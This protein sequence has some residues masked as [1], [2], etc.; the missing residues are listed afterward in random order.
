MLCFLNLFWFKIEILEISEF[1]TEW[2]FWLKTPTWHNLKRPKQQ[3]DLHRQISDCAFI[4]VKVA[5]QW[6][7]FSYPHMD[8]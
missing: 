3:K 6:L 1:S 5:W 8:F 7:Q 4:I 2:K